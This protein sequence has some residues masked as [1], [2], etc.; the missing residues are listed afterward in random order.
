MEGVSMGPCY[1]Q[2]S[3]YDKRELKWQA[4]LS[5]YLKPCSLA[6]Y[7]LSFPRSRYLE[8]NYSNTCVHG[9]GHFI[10]KLDHCYQDSYAHGHLTIQN[11]C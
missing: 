6:T 4:G 11:A 2:L 1:S 3:G 8:A 10:F 7:F 5:Y 9:G